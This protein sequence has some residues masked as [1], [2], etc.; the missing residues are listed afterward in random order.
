MAAAA[1]QR[2]VG[3]FAGSAGLPCAVHEMPQVVHHVPGVGV[4]IGGAFGKRLQANALQFLGNRRVDAPRRRRIFPQ[5]LFEQRV[6]RFRHERPLA[7][8]QFVEHDAQAEDVRACV[9]PMRFAP[10]LLGTHIAGRTREA[11]PVAR[12]PFGQRQSEV[13]DI[14]AAERV[15]QDVRRLHVAMHQPAR[16]RCVRARR[17]RSIVIWTASSHDSRDRWILA[18]QVLAANQ[19]RHNVAVPV[20][21]PADIVHGNDRRM[22]Q[23]RDDAGLGPIRFHRFRIGP[24]SPIRHLDGHVPPQFLIG[25]VVDAG[26]PAFPQHAQHPIAADRGQHLG[27]IARVA[28][29]GTKV[30]RLRSDFAPAARSP[31]RCAARPAA[32]CCSS[33][34][35]SASR[36]QPSFRNSSANSGSRSACCASTSS[37]VIDQPL[38]TLPRDVEHDAADLRRALGHPQVVR[39]SRWH[40]TARP[41]LTGTHL[42]K[43]NDDRPMHG[44]HSG[45][46][47]NTGPRTASRVRPVAAA[48][49]SKDCPNR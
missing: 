20:A 28:V 26:K 14:G 47:D 18:G 43:Y 8:E 3:R 29:A 5:H 42:V 44:A 41:A 40:R 35:C 15:Q 21:R 30:V 34:S 2:R 36:M 32:Y 6:V 19:L 27:D 16:V 45:A 12:V 48:I 38:R 7:G 4:A 39:G 13:D 1:Q 46:L 22:V 49:W 9:D 33:C 25:R 24:A 11:A 37:S 17:P 23:R 10:R 31:P